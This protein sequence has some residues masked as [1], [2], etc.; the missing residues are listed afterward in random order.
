MSDW[1]PG[2]AGA[3]TL[4]DELSRSESSSFGPRLSY[5]HFQRFV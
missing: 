4:V 5:W 2:L 1:L 3:L